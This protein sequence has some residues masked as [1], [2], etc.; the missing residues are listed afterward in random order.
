[1]ARRMGW[2]GRVKIQAV[3]APDGSVQSARVLES[4]G[5][6]ILD[7]SALSGVLQHRFTPG[8]DTETIVIA[9]RFKLKSQN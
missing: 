1:M 4:S 9:L 8:S 3:V 2:Q 5:Y 6:G 7:Q